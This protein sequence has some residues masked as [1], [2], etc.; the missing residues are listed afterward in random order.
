ML[1]CFVE[2]F[3][4]VEFRC[5]VW[6]FG[7][8]WYLFIMKEQV[9]GWVGILWRDS[10][11]RLVGRWQFSFI[12]FGQCIDGGLGRIQVYE[13]NVLVGERGY[14]TFWNSDNEGSFVIVRGRSIGFVGAQCFGWKKWIFVGFYQ[15]G[16]SRDLE[17]LVLG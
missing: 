6:C 9:W 15:V 13:V 1:I 17:F 14:W 16:R 8:Y 11:V 7:I 2:G 12:A 10:V 5:L 3:Q 4:K